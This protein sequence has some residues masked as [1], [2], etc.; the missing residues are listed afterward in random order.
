MNKKQKEDAK[1]TSSLDFLY[2]FLSNLI[3]F[4]PHGSNQTS[5]GEIVGFPT[6]ITNIYIDLT[7]ILCADQFCQIR[8]RNDLPAVLQQTF[9]QD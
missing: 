6:K 1:K 3:P 8:S 5:V 2:L 4:S 7:R 9:H